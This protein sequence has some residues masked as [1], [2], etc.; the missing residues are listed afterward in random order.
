VHQIG[1]SL[2]I[3]RCRLELADDAGTLVMSC[4]GEDFPTP[5]PCN[6]EKKNVNNRLK[7]FSVE[8]TFNLR[9]SAVVLQAD[10]NKQTNKQTKT[11]VVGND[12]SNRC[13]ALHHALPS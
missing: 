11:N 7:Y 12:A 8:Y 1:A 4:K 5:L 6:E 13:L 3:M 2:I 9:V 10:L